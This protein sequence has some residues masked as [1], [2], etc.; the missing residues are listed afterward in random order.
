MTTVIKSYIA[1]AVLVLLGLG[2]YSALQE[3]DKRIRAEMAIK[4]SE[5]K[6]TAIKKNTDAK[7]NAIKKKAA[8]VKTTTEAIAAMPDVS[9]LPLNVRPLPDL[10]TAV[11]VEAV[12]LYQELAACRITETKLQGCEA[13]AAEKDTQITAL[14]SK[15][16][17]WKRVTR[18]AEVLAVGAA[19]GYVAHR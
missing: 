16:S 15:G 8:T 1:A 4:A 10:P 17:F 11:A 2:G 18:T 13:T 7:V 5:V 19:I 6:V 12:P 3:H 14:K 9:T